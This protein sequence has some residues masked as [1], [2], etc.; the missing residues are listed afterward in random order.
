VLGIDAGA[1]P[2]PRRRVAALLDELVASGHTSRALI[3]APLRLDHGQVGEGYELITPAARQAMLDAGR[4]EGIVLDP[5]YTA[6]ALAGLIAA[7]RSGEIG[8]GECTVFVHTG[9][10][11]GLFGHPIASEIAAGRRAPPQRP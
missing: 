1:V 2:D 7:V 5:V 10:L 6:K 3:D 8:T 11:P 4:Y 9:G